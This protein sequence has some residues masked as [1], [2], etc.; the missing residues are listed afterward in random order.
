MAR[1]LH[2]ADTGKLRRLTYYLSRYASQIE[3]DFS[4]EYNGIDLGEL[5]RS[6]KWRKLLNHIDRLPRASLFYSAVADDEEH[7]A[8]ILEAEERNPDLKKVGSA[9]HLSD[10]TPV[11]E[12]LDI[13]I[14]HVDGVMGAVVAGAGGKPPRLVPRPR[15]ETAYERVAHRRRSAQQQQIASRM[16]GK[17]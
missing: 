15:P 8:M 4:R 6:R 14:D 17:R 1:A 10:Y 13:L 5:W 11:V 2:D 16:L 9:P 7:V 3:V 12:R